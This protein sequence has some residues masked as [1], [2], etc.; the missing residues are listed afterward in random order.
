MGHCASET[1]DLNW[2]KWHLEYK[3]GGSYT[4]SN[5]RNIKGTVLLA[6]CLWEVKEKLVLVSNYARYLNQFHYLLC[7]NVVIAL[8]SVVTELQPCGCC[9]KSK[10]LLRVTVLSLEYD[11]LLKLKFILYASKG[12]TC[13]LFLYW[14][15]RV[16]F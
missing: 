9:S 4:T 1:N 8:G 10:T 3:N 6:L 13:Y 15:L 5:D 2:F 12:C 16:P 11:C 7:Y 14:S